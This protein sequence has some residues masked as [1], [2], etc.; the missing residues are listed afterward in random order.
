M[1]ARKVAGFGQVSKAVI[2]DPDLSPEAKAIY[3]A[4]CCYADKAGSCFPSV[5]LLCSVLRMDERRLRRHMQPLLDRGIVSKIREREGNLMQGNVYRIADDVRQSDPAILAP[6]KP[7]PPIL[8]ASKPD[9]AISR[10]CHSRPVQDGSINNTIMN[11]TISIEQNQ[12]NRVLAYVCQCLNDRRAELSCKGRL[13]PSGLGEIEISEL[14]QSC[15]SEEAIRERA[16]YLSE[17]GTKEELEWIS[18]ADSFLHRKKKPIRPYTRR[19]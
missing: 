13:K 9:P 7:D 8:E 6:S 12:I 11:K 19:K 5:S 14:L 2:C 15:I 4:L 3:A 10:S 16:K 18:F 17:Y 1:E